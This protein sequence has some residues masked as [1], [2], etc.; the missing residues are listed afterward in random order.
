MARFSHVIV[1]KV[2]YFWVSWEASTEVAGETWNRKIYYALH[3]LT[4]ERTP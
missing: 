2:D 1:T 3:A 4:N